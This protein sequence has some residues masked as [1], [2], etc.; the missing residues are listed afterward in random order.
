MRKDED[1]HELQ[2]ECSNE[3]KSIVANK[4]FMEIL[5]PM[6]DEYTRIHQP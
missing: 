2:L 4:I 5:A 1:A 6:T 3:E